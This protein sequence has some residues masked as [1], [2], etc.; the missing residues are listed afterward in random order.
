MG[1]DKDLD[2]LRLALAD[3]IATSLSYVPSL[4]IRPFATTSK[5]DSPTVDLQEAG[6]AMRVTDVVTGHFLKE[7]TQLQITLEAIDIA[8]NRTVWRDTMT[9]A[10][11]DLIAM[12]D[13][14]HRKSSPGPG[15]RTGRGSGLG[16]RYAP[17]ERRGLRFIF[18]QHRA[19]A[20]S[21]AE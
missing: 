14:D 20:R 17:E 15:A 8:D 7:G 4:T 2:F 12:R 1:G 5:Y 3:E 9:V 6:H 11:P 13:R 16:Q 10:A 21:A 19:A 18:A